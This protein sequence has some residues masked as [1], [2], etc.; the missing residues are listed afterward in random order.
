MVNTLINLQ[1]MLQVDFTINQEKR[2]KIG[3]WETDDLKWRKR[4]KIPKSYI[5]ILHSVPVQN[6][7]KH[8]A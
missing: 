2:T 7:E 3:V 6:S 5:S 1:S 8:P 4:A